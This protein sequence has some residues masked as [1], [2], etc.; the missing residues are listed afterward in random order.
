MENPGKYAA[1][2]R[3]CRHMGHSR[4]G[5]CRSSTGWTGRCGP[6]R[7]RI[8]AGI[9]HFH[10]IGPLVLTGLK[11]KK[12]TEGLGGLPPKAPCVFFSLRRGE[13]GTP[14]PRPKQG[15]GAAPQALA[16]TSGKRGRPA[17]RVCFKTG[18]MPVFCAGTRAFKEKNRKRIHAF[19]N[20]NVCKPFS[21]LRGLLTQKAPFLG[22]TGGV[23]KF[24]NRL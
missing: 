10:V 2:R 6:S 23:S 19:R 17:P 8:L 4:H 3:A 1:R 13:G 15:F 20:T 16:R 5:P 24:Y 12:N 7:P 21:Y 14:A 22:E 18:G 9:R 11:Q